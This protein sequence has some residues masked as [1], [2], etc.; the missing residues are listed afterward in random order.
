VT[1][2]ATGTLDVKLAPQATDA[3]PNS[4]TLARMS[5]DKQFQGDLEGPS[6]GEMLSAGTPVKG[7]RA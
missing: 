3:E 4:S 1:A 7:W 6:E 2:H 5:I